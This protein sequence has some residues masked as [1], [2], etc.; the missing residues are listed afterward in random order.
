MGAAGALAAS[1]VL[2]QAVA[3]ATL[4]DPAGRAADLAFFK[5]AYEEI[6]PG[7]WRYQTPASW[8]AVVARLGDETSAAPD[9]G[10]YWLAYARATAAVRCGHSYVSPF[11]MGKLWTEVMAARQ[12]RLPFHFRWLDRQMVVTKPLVEH[13]AL[14]AGTRVSTL[15]GEADHSL[16]ARMLPLARADGGNDFKRVANMEVRNDAS[17]WENFDVMWALD[18]TPRP[19]SARQLLEPP[20]GDAVL[21]ELP[22]LGRE[23]RAGGAKVERLGWAHRHA[24]DATIL[25]MPSWT[26]YNQKWDWRGWLTEV[27]DEAVGRGS[28]RFVLDL[29]GNE[30]GEDCGDVLLA[31]MIDTPLNDPGAERRV[32]FRETPVEMRPQLDTWDDS[33]HTLGKDASGPD[34]AGFYTLTSRA[35]DG[36]APAPGPRLTA[37]LIV[38]IDSANSSATF[39]FAQ[40]VRRNGLG[41]LLGEPTGGNQRGI[42]GGAFFFTRLPASRLEVD[43]PLI[44]YFPPGTPPDAGLLP[45]IAVATTRRSIATGE[46]PQMTRALALPLG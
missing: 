28:K 14:R 34:A 17:L 27:I 39:Q 18:R 35:E 7:L 38:L 6:H 13:P 42:N 45:D 36:L 10:H 12:D 19:N 40:A 43:L 31:R 37:K 1:P 30:G 33:F 22:L 16:L 11:N 23:S 21:A 3:P 29:R 25:T 26:T 2:G 44:G 9:P 4:P 32:R 8:R 20:G 24:G 15:N 5:R 41:V 46:D